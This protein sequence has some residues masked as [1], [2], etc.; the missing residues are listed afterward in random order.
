MPPRARTGR[1]FDVEGFDRGARRHIA[2]TIS[3][4]SDASTRLNIR[5]PARAANYYFAARPTN[6]KLGD[7][8]CDRENRPHLYQRR[9]AR[10][11]R[12]RRRSTRRRI[13]V[14]AA[15]QNR[16]EPVRIR[17]RYPSGGVAAATPRAAASAAR[18]RSQR[19]APRQGAAHGQR[20][21]PKPRHF[22]V[23]I[24]KNPQNHGRTTL[25]VAE[26]RRAD[27]VRAENRDAI[28]D[29][30]RL[31]QHC[32]RQSSRSAATPPGSRDWSSMA[33][34]RNPARTK[35]RCSSIRRRTSAAKSAGR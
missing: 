16:H 17:M 25:P 2:F 27:E 6:L 12:P 5:R 4:C 33:W 9:G 23:K 28:A 11:G 15:D 7:P 34:S 21:W 3:R 26:S 19:P 13:A 31:S 20:S 30:R 10:A 14:G 22:T 24:K 35:T 8:R 1:T 32:G 18:V 29:A